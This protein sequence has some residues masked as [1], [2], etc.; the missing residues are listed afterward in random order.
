LCNSASRF[1]GLRRFIEANP[2]NKLSADSVQ[3]GGGH[4]GSVLGGIDV[5]PE[6]P[7]AKGHVHDF[8]NRISHRRHIGVGRCDGV[9]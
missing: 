4:I 9:R 7:L 5:D 2:T 6:R 3:D 1:R 8:D